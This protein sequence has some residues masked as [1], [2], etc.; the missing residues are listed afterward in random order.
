LP[1]SVHS[2]SKAGGFVTGKTRGV[3]AKA[4]SQLLEHRK[5]CS[6]SVI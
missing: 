1:H 5:W 4:A 2:C 3:V 6:Y